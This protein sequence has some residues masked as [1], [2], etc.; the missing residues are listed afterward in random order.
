MARK[1]AF[2]DK[3]FCIYQGTSDDLLC[4][5]LFDVLFLTLNKGF[6]AVQ[7]S[8][9]FTVSYWVS[10]VLQSP[11]YWLIKKLKAGG[12]VVFGSFLFLFAALFITFGN[13]VAVVTIGQ[14]LYQIAALF[15]GMSSAILENAMNENG[16]KKDYV[17]LMSAANI[18]FSVVSLIAS[19]LVNRLL[20]INPNLPMLIC[21][22]FCVNS[23]VLA[24]IISR[25]DTSAAVDTQRILVPGRKTPAMDRV[26]LI[27]L[28]LSVV[29]NVILM[30]SGPNLRLYLEDTLSDAFGKDR[31]VL[32]YSMVMIG[33]RVFK[34]LSNISAYIGRRK[35]LGQNHGMVL[36]ICATA[37]ISLF[38]VSAH[39]GSGVLPAALIAAGILMRSVVHDPYRVLVSDFM[40]RRLK[41]DKMVSVLYW[42]SLCKS[43]LNAVFS[44]LATVIIAV[45]G[46]HSV[47]MM[48]LGLS[49]VML[50]TSHLLRRQIDGRTSSRCFRRWSP[51]DIDKA[52]DL[53]MAAAVLME[54]YRAERGKAVTPDKLAEKLNDIVTFMTFVTS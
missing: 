26:T 28:A 21:I 12:S 43:L 19:C 46:L 14:C 16:Q 51:E 50:V 34:L 49:V 3:L 45:G 44:S 5:A 48:L 27:C 15:Q 32:L 29:G 47:M 25:Y 54:H 18:V 11:S 1:A 20:A 10:I 8:L 13:S 22:A 37:S 36:V 42:D 7:I 24:V 4:W 41:R 33:T 31:E 52:D 30:V 53:S 38:G 40:L 6:T 39:F 9:V 2:P 35:N 23:C 17:R